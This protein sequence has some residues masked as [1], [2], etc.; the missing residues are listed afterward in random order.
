[1]TLDSQAVA[2]V[3]SDPS[4]K[5]FVVVTRTVPEWALGFSQAR[6]SQKHT[7]ERVSSHGHRRNPSGTSAR[8]KT[9]RARRSGHRD[10]HHRSGGWEASSR[11][12]ATG[13]AGRRTGR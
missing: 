6:E 9:C 7:E 2:A 13:D 3:A 12:T 11:T 10:L 5:L 8:A 4:V 1:M